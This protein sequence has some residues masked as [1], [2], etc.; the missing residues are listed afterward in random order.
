M[1]AALQ[2]WLAAARG[3]K[4]RKVV[5]LTRS[6]TIVGELRVMQATT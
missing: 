2:Q 4:G 5:L 3:P 1:A 6:I